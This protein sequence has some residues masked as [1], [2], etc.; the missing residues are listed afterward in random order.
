MQIGVFSFSAY[1]PPSK[2][3]ED[4][5]DYWKFG[6]I[7]QMSNLNQMQLAL[8][9]AKE[10]ILKNQTCQVAPRCLAL[11][12]EKCM[13]FSKDGKKGSKKPAFRWLFLQ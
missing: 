9:K 2:D 1:Y 12:E 8:D 10:S 4:P 7:H 3:S 6:E 11:V 5:C 13:M